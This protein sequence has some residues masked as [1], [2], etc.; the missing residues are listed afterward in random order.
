MVLSVCGEP[1]AVLSEN[2]MWAHTDS[3]AH[4][5]FVPRPPVLSESTCRLTSVLRTQI[6]QVPLPWRGLVQEPSTC[7]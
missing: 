1:R 6:S 7:P 2:D 3:P 5:Q 4:P